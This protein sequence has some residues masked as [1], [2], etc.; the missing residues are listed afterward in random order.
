MNDYH[1]DY[2]NHNTEDACVKSLL[3]CT[4]KEEL[5]SSKKR[6]C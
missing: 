6:L 1:H 2:D 3:M 5:L 4:Q